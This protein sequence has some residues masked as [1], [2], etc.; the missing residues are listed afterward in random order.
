MDK[1]KNAIDALAHPGHGAH[2]AQV[3]DGGGTFLL[4]LVLGL[5]GLSLIALAAH[6]LKKGE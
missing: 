6:A 4:W 1:M 2:D 5:V 3:A